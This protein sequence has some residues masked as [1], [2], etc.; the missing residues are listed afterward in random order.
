[1]VKTAQVFFCL[2]LLPTGDP[3]GGGHQCRLAC[4]T[5]LGGPQAFQGQHRVHRTQLEKEALPR[6]VLNPGQ[7]ARE[8]LKGVQRTHRAAVSRNLRNPL[9][10]G[11]SVKSLEIMRGFGAL[12]KSLSGNR[13]IDFLHLQEIGSYKF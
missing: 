2:W 11:Q 5:G 13:W 9:T 4:Y 7:A 6:P 12:D 3:G 10:S 1:M 8:E